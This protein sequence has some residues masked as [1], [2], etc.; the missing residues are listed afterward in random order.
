M[1]K[2]IKKKITS[3]PFL[4]SF[5][6]FLSRNGSA[7]KL[8][9]PLTSQFMITPPSTSLIS[10]N[11]TLLAFSD[12][13]LD[14]SLMFPGPGIP[15]QS[16]TAS[17]PSDMSLPPECPPREHQG[18]GLHSVFQTFAENPFLYPGMIVNAIVYVRRRWCMC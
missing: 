1:K 13:H 17:E 16:G 8:S 14:L 9:L 15:R 2:K 10:K 3:L 7:T 4:G 11:P 18:E 5:I 12:Q 6:G